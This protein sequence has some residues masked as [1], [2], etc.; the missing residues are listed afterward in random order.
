MI[1][2]IDTTKDGQGKTVLDN[3]EAT[4]KSKTD[5]EY[6]DASGLNISHCL[7]CNYCWLKTPGECVVKD[8]YEPILKKI[9]KSD[10]VWLITDTR[11]GF[12]SYETKNIVDR[13]MPLV[14]MNI[15]MVGKQMRHVMRYEKNPDWGVIYTGDGDKDY[16]TKWCER[17]AINF[18]GKSLGAYRID[19]IEEAVKCM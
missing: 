4:K 12:V 9:S 19:E 5:Y 17:V 15:H 3:V 8:D 2:L 11:F 13:V 10:Q 18:A 14:T 16:L 7:G 1:I 6:I